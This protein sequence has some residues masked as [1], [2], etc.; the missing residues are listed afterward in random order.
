MKFPI[1]QIGLHG[2]FLTVGTAV[3]CMAV[4]LLTSGEV[5]PEQFAGTAAC[6]AVLLL[7]LLVA[8]RLTRQ[9]GKTRI[10]VALCLGGV[11]LAVC[12]LLGALVG[13]TVQWNVWPGFVLAVCVLAG[14]LASAKKQYRR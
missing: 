10:Q 14:V 1:K 3:I 8:L 5:I 4:G 6:V 9:I 13:G 12:F 7:V 11:Y 2:I